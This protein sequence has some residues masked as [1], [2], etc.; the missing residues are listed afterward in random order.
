MKTSNWIFTLLIVV[1]IVVTSIAFRADSEGDEMAGI[2]LPK[3][4]IV[5]GLVQYPS[6]PPMFIDKKKDY[7]ATIKTNKGDFHIDLYEKDAPLTVNNFVF[8]AR[9][10]F[11]NDVIFHRVIEEFMI[12][13]GDPQGTGI[14]GPGYSFEDELNGPHKYEEGVVAMANAGPNTNGSQFFIG[15]GQAIGNLNQAPNYTIFGKVTKG[16]DVV[17]TIAAT[18]VVAGM[19]GE[20]SQPT[21]PLLI[22]KIEIQ[23]K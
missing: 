1:A 18:P 4:Q 20:A 17:K 15:T 2:N 7:T 11:Y 5:D 21:E 22:E 13:T 9:D 16:M 14:G 6:A 8:L 10:E 19:S 23:S 12:Q 3:K